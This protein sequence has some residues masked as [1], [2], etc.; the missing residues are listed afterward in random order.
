M[1]MFSLI[2]LFCILG[3][4]VSLGFQ[5]FSK[6]SKGTSLSISKVH[7]GIN[8]FLKVVLLKNRLAEIACE[9]C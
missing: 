9:C 6:F 7:V 3:L 1:C 4:C 2:P 5:H 8:A